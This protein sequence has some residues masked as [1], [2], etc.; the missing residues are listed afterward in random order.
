MEVLRVIA[1]FVLVMLLGLSGC[2][3]GGG[4]Q[5]EG[6]A[7]IAVAPTISIQPQDLRTTSGQMATFAVTAT[8]DPTVNYQWSRDGQVIPGATSASYAI[9][10]AALG[11]EGSQF[12]VVVSNAAGAV[13][14]ASATLQVGAVPGVNLLAGDT[15]GQGYTDGVGSAARFRSLNASTIAVD[16]SGTTYIPDAG[17]HI[18]RKVTSAGV[19]STFAGTPGQSG[20][21]DGVGSAARF[22]NPRGVA[23]DGSGNLYVTDFGNYTVRKVSPAG[24]VTTLAGRP[25]TYGSSDGT[26]AAAGFGLLYAIASDPDGTVYVGDESSVRKVTAGGVVTTLTGSPGQTGTADGAGAAAR[27]GSYLPSMAVDADGNVFVLDAF[28]ATIRKVTPGGIVTTFVGAADQ[29]GNVDGA[30]GAARINDSG[31]LSFNAAGDLIV[32]QYT[33]VDPNCTTFIRKV[34]KLGAITTAAASV[35]G[36]G[37]MV[38]AGAER[39]GGVIV[40]GDLGAT[41]HRVSMD[42]SVTYLAGTASKSGFVNGPGSAARLNS[43][44]AVAVDASGDAYVGDTGNHAIRKVTPTGV[45][46]TLA[47]GTSGI[48]DGTG[49]AAQFDIINA[50]AIDAQ[51]NLL[52]VE[53]RAKMIRKVT[54]AGVVTTIADASKFVHA[55]GTSALIEGIAV[56]PS[57]NV[58]V[59]DLNQSVRSISPSGVVSIVSPSGC[60]SVVADRLGNIYLGKVDA[61]INK[62]NLDGSLTLI[63]G[64]SGESGYQDG[65]GASARFNFADVESAT[66][67]MATDATGNIYLVD[68]GNA[69]IRKITPSGA[70]TTVAGVGRLA[71]VIPGAPGGLNKPTGLAIAPTL[72]GVT[73]LV[74]DFAEH[75]LLRVVI[76]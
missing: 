12:R 72:S 45:V 9:S 5:A 1:Q 31:R 29:F 58:L 22:S 3:G 7:P 55:D 41:L 13:S 16:A 4:G 35:R 6:A 48:F 18:I 43:P 73:L 14:S 57:G 33:Y 21:V 36:L 74:T 24:V 39:A 17:N 23:L 42:G 65:T 40:L 69:V 19:V 46:S 27:F 54:P 11:D 56:D 47:G 10:N 20:S 34:D 68:G 62:L 64:K 59:C 60:M 28:H 76:P 50:M 53:P 67:A 2:G 49:T 26:G 32:V 70:V 61:T 37:C 51:G 66:G 63:A 52:V 15:G 25:G 38:A 71:Q 44:F 30:G 75:A 8:G